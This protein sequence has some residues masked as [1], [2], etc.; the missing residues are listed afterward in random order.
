MSFQDVVSRVAEIQAMEQLLLGRQPAAAS[1]VP[2]ASTASTSGTGASFAD[3]LGNALTSSPTSA[4]AAGTAPASGTSTAPVATGPAVAPPTVDPDPGA[5][6]LA[7][8]QTEI[9][10]AEEPPGS[11]DS[12]RI[13]VYRSAV[14]GAVAGEPWCAYFVSWAAAQ[15]G[16]PLGDNG[17]GLGS[18]AQITDWARRT[19]KL[20]PAGATPRPGD[21]ILFGTH[22]VGIVESVAADGTI[23]TVE[24]N[25]GDAVRRRQRAPSEATGFVRL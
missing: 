3:V 10:Q 4:T 19:G 17:E 13:A 23:T 15:A 22:H 18:V 12:P 8:A 5:K 20:L 6:A 1:T 11:N 7:A 25:T 2:A 16:A 24:G 14:Q 21:L 9:G